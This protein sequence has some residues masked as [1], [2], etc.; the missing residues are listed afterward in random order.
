M[1]FNIQRIV[2][3]YYHCLGITDV[4]FKFYSRCKYL[5]VEIIRSV[6]EGNIIYINLHCCPI[7]HASRHQILMCL[8][9]VTQY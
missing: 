9:D 7:N 3:A 5:I 2:K 4:F 1:S 8:P 6:W